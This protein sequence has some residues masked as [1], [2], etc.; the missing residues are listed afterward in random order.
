MKELRAVVVGV[1]VV[2]VIALVWGFV[3][4]PAPGMNRVRSF[5]VEIEGHE[6]GR[7]KHVSVRLPG[8][9]VGKVSQLVSRSWDDE[10]WRDWSFSVDGE[11]RRITPRDIQ[12]AADKS[13]EGKPSRIEIRGDEALEVLAEGSAVRIRVLHGAG[14]RE[15]EVVLPKELLA[16]LAQEKSIT[17]Q[18]ILRRIDRL[19]PGE[20]VSIRGED[21]SVRIVAEGRE[22]R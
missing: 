20:I 5:R 10:D 4:R 22:K 18:R 1:V 14:R 3:R 13:S 12:D 19:G 7:E 8:F 15:A 9:L 21:G 11:E 6:N 16:G 17:P 2:V